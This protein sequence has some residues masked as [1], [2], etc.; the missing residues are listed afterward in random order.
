VLADIS[1]LDLI[2]AFYDQYALP[3]HGIDEG[4]PLS[5]RVAGFEGMRVFAGRIEELKALQE[6]IESRFAVRTEAR[7][8][9]VESVLGLG[10]NLDLALLLTASVAALG[11]A[12]TLIFSFWSEVA[13]K[14]RMI[15]S[16]ALL[17]IPARRIAVFP[18]I[19][20][21]V[22]AAIG[23][24][25]SFLLLGIAAQVA[26]LLFETG[27]ASGG[28]VRISALEAVLISLGVMVFVALSAAAA[29]RRASVIDPAIVLRETA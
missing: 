20:A 2:E 25:V 3:E 24:G 19:Q 1:T 12:A 18:V 7:T 15:A 11:L 28:L 4:R 27:L 13:R 22:T 14:R 21:L 16:L 5:D 17:G 10:R 6:R 29:A 8:R 23:L 26:A 9:E